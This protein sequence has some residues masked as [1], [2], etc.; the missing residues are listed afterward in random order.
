MM[1]LDEQCANFRVSKLAS[2]W[3]KKRSEIKKQAMCRRLAEVQKIYSSSKT[4][5]HDEERVTNNQVKNRQKKEGEEE[6][7]ANDRCL[8]NLMSTG[9][10][11]KHYLHRKIAQR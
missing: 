8:K 10:Q 5:G 7:L 6:S 1:C 9:V 11:Y 4:S 2:E 3:Q